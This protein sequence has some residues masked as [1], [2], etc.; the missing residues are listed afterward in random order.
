MSLIQP[1]CRFQIKLLTLSSEIKDVAQM[2]TVSEP[3]VPL[4][5]PARSQKAIFI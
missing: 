2:N 5:K 3:R 4:G 1:S